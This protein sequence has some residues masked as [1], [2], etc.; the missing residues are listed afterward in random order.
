M[1]NTF[2]KG[3]YEDHYLAHH[4][5]LGMKWGVRRYQNP[6]GSLT[7]AG[8]RRYDD[9]VRKLD[10]MSGERTYKKL[11]REV[12][13]KR[14]EL[15]GGSN[16]WMANNPIG[17]NSKKVLEESNRKRKEYKS[18]KEYKEWE[19]KVSKFEK[20]ANQKIDSGKMTFDEYDKAWESLIK[21]KPKKNFEDAGAWAIRYTSKGRVYADDYLNKGGKTLSLAYLKDL[22]YDEEAAKRFVKKMA[23]ANRTLGTT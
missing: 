21:E 20:V 6:D 16:R 22:G 3:Y 15:L 5:I 23:K 8:R 10:K 1:N 17:E 4:G 2:Y 12:H 14:A 13:S 9:K 11:K 18:S 7:E 19:K